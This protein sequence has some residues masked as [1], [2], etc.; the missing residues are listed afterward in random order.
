MDKCITI[1]PQHNTCLL[2]YFKLLKKNFSQPTKPLSHVL[3]IGTDRLQL[4]GLILVLYPHTT[5]L[6]CFTTFLQ[7]CVIHVAMILQHLPQSHS[8]LSCGVYAVAENTIHLAPTFLSRTPTLCANLL[9]ST[10]LLSALSGV[11]C[12]PF[13]A[14]AG[15][16]SGFCCVRVL[17]GVFPTHRASL[18]LPAT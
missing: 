17:C 18:N 10:Q 14:T 6:P 2:K 1:F 5:M 3:P 9:C 7:C 11:G 13:Q 12:Q 8:L 15:N 4:H 16:R